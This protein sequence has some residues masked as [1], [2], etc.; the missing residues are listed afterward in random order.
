M[1][2]F[3]DI[4]DKKRFKFI[5]F[6]ICEFYP[7]ITLE[8][9]TEAIE[10]AENFVTISD[11]EKEIILQAKQSLLYDKN[12]PWVKKNNPTFDVG[13]G[14]FDSA[15]CCD[16]VGLFLLSKL[17]NLNINL[18]LYRDDGLGVSAST[19]R[20]IDK[21]KKEM[22]KIFESYNLRITID[23]NHKIVDFLDVTFNLESG[24]YQPFLKPN[25]S[26]IYVN[27][28]SNHPPC[29]LKNLPASVNKRL[30]SIS[31]NEGVFRE[32]IPPYKNA[33]RESGY[34]T[35]LKFENEVNSG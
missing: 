21:T 18:G 1:E 6:D 13:M 17:S 3:K 7:S 11:E 33:L 16:L 25:D 4:K 22:C 2:W 15:E 27:K 30:S 34:D 8:L 14:S 20:Q 28:D 24:L 9:L 5:L 31:S 26:P 35:E 29:I 32:A 19:P 23:V 12:T 10:F